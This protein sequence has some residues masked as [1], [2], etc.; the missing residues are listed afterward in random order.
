MSEHETTRSTPIEIEVDGSWEAR[1]LAEVLAPFHAFMVQRDHARWMVHARAPGCHGEPLDVA[2]AAVEQWRETR[3][4][5][6]A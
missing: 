2:L 5:S 6:A 3:E 4:R 1:A